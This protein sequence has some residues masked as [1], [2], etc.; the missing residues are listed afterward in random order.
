MRVIDTS[1]LKCPQPIIET[2]KALTGS[3]GGEIFQV[4]I[5]NPTSFRNVTRFLNDNKISFSASELKGKWTLTVNSGKAELVT[6][7]AEDYCETVIPANN[8]SGY[9]VAISS[10]LMGSGD[11][12]LGKKLMRSFFVTLSCMDEAPSVI[13]FYNSGVR[14]LVS[15]SEIIEIVSEM[16]AKGVEVYVCGT[17]LDH[18]KLTEKIVAGKIGDMLTIIS[19]LAASGNVL[20]P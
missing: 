4:I 20:R 11:D 16:E 12:E 19:K 7:K 10:E 9:G 3:S 17:C 18:Y 5:D 1:G 6:S 15:D 14:L 13:A 8:G 2:K